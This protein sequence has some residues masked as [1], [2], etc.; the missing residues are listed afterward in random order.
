MKFAIPGV[1]TIL[2]A[3][4]YNMVDTFFLGKY[5]G[6]N[7]VGALGI[8]F[9]VQRLI[10]ATSLMVAI[11]ASTTVAR[12]VGE[13]NY[14]RVNESIGNA[15]TLGLII[16]II[17]PILIF[18]LRKQ[19]LFGLGSSQILFPI[20]EEY[21]NII[22]LGSLFLSFTNILG[23]CIISLG[24]PRVTVIALSIGA[25]TNMV[26][27]YVLVGRLG[28][29]VAGAAI[30]TVASQALG[31]TYA[32][33]KMREYG[34]VIGL[35]LKL[36][37]KM[38]IWRNILAIGFA[39]FIVEI[40][41]AVVIGLLNNLLLP[42]GGDK[43]VI[44]V[45][46]ITRVS[47]FM[48]ITIIGISAGMQP[49]AA[50]NYGAG[51]HK[52]LKEVVN[53]TIKMGSMTSVVLWG[54]MMI[55][56]N[57][58]FSSFIKEPDI[59]VETVKAF[60]TTIIIFP[61]ISIYYVSIYYNQAINKAKV[62]FFLSIYRQLLLFI[63]IVIVLVNRMGITGAWITYPVTDIIA[64]ITGMVFIKKGLGTLKRDY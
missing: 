58:I 31:F 37:F 44:I 48:Y 39:T 4:L 12:A 9:P 60:R 55:F 30:A 5:V 27:D 29:G 49:L 54:F 2:V 3:E 56:S 26:V 23:Y 19:L 36:Y 59:L 15:I 17:L 7:A 45:G 25:I 43:S 21:V 46:A 62:S 50:Y 42:F 38:D 57:Q 41:D 32:V 40:S 6:A 11:G 47:M 53:M 18:V 64:A 22:L 61:V 10:I 24:N 16:S 51:N 33:F 35:K 20:V 34:K 13:K 8:A 52:K 1:A 28:M 14:K 63:P